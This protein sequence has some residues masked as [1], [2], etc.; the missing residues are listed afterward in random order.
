M[1]FRERNK[2][3]ALEGIKVF[4]VE[5]PEIKAVIKNALHFVAG[6]DLIGIVVNDDLP[7][8]RSCKAPPEKAPDIQK[9][10]SIISYFLINIIIGLSKVHDI[11]AIMTMIREK[12]LKF[13]CK[14]LKGPG[15]GFIH[16]L[17]NE[18]KTI[19]KVV[20]TKILEVDRI[21]T[22]QEKIAIYLVIT[23]F[24]VGINGHFSHKS[25]FTR[26][27]KTKNTSDQR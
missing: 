12:V 2:R 4:V 5:R 15:V 19:F 18:D 3:L 17:V 1:P 27:R 6:H 25:R 9:L 21:C 14:G 11:A 20:Y 23:F 26:P 16:G 13:I 10:G 22:G 7:D 24:L 8:D